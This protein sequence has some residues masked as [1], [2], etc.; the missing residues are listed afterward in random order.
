[1][2]SGFSATFDDGS[3]ALVHS[4]GRHRRTE[5]H[6]RNVRLQLSAD[7]EVGFEHS[8]L[9]KLFCWANNSFAHL[10]NSYMC[11]GGYPLLMCLALAVSSASDRISSRPPTLTP[12]P[13]CQP[14]FD[15]KG[16]R[17]GPGAHAEHREAWCHIPPRRRV[18]CGCFG[19][20]TTFVRLFRRQGGS[21]HRIGW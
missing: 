11:V 8:W 14:W 21:H 4:T 15:L 13:N 6:Q 3:D 7:T 18:D 19:A 2:V 10:I 20:R 9:F 5:A 17:F 16:L 12:V 1:V